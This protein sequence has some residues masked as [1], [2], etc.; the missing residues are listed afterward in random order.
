MQSRR[1]FLRHVATAG[2]VGYLGLSPRPVAAEPPPETAR[3]RMVQIPGICIAPV[4]VAEQ[5]L[6]AEGFTELQYVKQNAVAQLYKSLAAG[7]AD[8]NMAYIAPWIIQ[9]DAGDVLRVEITNVDS[10]YLTP[11]RVAS[12]T[13]ISAVGVDLPLRPLR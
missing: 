7:D 10:P 4:Y 13:L 3:L 5:L 11:S 6:R 2:T 8:I 12:V 9:I 1:E